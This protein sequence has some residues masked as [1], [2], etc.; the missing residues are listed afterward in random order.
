MAR[1]TRGKGQHLPCAVQAQQP[2]RRRRY[3]LTCVKGGCRCATGGQQDCRVGFQPGGQPK[4]AG[5]SSPCDWLRCGQGPGMM[6]QPFGTEQVGTD[7]CLVLPKSPSPS[8][9]PGRG[10][11]VA[12]VFHPSIRARR[13]GPGPLR[14]R[15]HRVVASA[16]RACGFRDRSDD[17]IRWAKV[18][19]GQRGPVALHPQGHCRPLPFDLF[20]IHLTVLPRTLT[21][22]WHQ[23][24]P[25][26]NVMLVP[27]VPGGRK[28]KSRITRLG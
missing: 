9:Q 8:V 23:A 16:V 19:L 18:G 21:R 24:P 4:D 7:R 14:G 17:V 27:N 12:Q 20:P 5:R 2:F 25:D 15:L 11:V 3:G 28:E 6:L 22:G 13:A 26:Q 1:E 10:R